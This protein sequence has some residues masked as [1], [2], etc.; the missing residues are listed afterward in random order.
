MGYIKQTS[1]VFLICQSNDDVHLLLIKEMTSLV[2]P[3][4]CGNP[5][6]STSV[7]FITDSFVSDLVENTVEEFSSNIFL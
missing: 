4:T 5:F 6:W 1:T 2:F 7:A 3:L